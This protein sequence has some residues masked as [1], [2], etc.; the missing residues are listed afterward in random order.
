MHTKWWLESL[1]VV[2]FEWHWAAAYHC[3][4]ITCCRISSRNY[5]L[6]VYFRRCNYVHNQGSIIFSP[7]LSEILRTGPYLSES[8]QDIGRG[9]WIQPRGYYL[10][11]Q[12]SYS[13]DRHVGAQ[14]LCS[15][16]FWGL[17]RDQES[18]PRVQNQWWCIKYCIFLQRKWTSAKSLPQCFL[19]SC[20]CT[21]NGYGNSKCSPGTI[22]LNFCFRVWLYSLVALPRKNL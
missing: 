3:H 12:Y 11:S 21:R 19:A 20:L 7:A 1:R 2:S 6:L 13:W 8:F 9:S 17:W 4:G 5:C 18:L 14:Q 16:L 22:F 10:W 15:W